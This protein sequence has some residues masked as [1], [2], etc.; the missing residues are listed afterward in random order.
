M[1]IEAPTKIEFICKKCG[2]KDIRLKGSMLSCNIC[3]PKEDDDMKKAG[4]EI[5]KEEERQNK[6]DQDVLDEVKKQVTQEVFKLIEIEIKETEG[7][8]GF[9]I[10][11]EK[12][13]ELD[14]CIE[15][16]KVW[17]NQWSVGESGDSFEGNV[18]VELPN[19]KYLKWSYST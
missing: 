2:G 16:I 1:E 13:G 9:E 14:D 8:I 17:I 11:D 4:E 5:A 12:S 3:F 7:G 15:G 10:V 19:K 6:K 18:Y